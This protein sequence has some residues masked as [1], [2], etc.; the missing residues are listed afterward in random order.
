LSNR[1]HGGEANEADLL[2]NLIAEMIPHLEKMAGSVETDLVAV[3]ENNGKAGV[4]QIVRENGTR[5]ETVEPSHITAEEIVRIVSAYKL[6]HAQGLGLVFLMDRLVKAH[7]TGCLYVVFFDV[8]SRKVL[9]SQR[10]IASAGGFGFRN[11]WFRPVKE[12]V[13][14]LTPMYKRIKSKKYSSTSNA[15]AGAGHDVNQGI[16]RAR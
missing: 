5:N 13:Q 2:V 9:H 15:V 8:H 7:S 16:S 1:S 3:E 6:K 10:I 12:S 4:A 14:K 11:F